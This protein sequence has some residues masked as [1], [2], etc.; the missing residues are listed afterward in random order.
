[1]LDVAR[2]FFSVE[3]V[4]HYIDLISHY[5]INRLHLHLTDDQ[6]WRIEIKSL[7]K[8]TEIG[9]QTQV[10]GGGGGFYKQAEYQ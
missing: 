9:A 4:K 2:H 10:N 7:P 3:D 8:L 1:M 6:G 5:K